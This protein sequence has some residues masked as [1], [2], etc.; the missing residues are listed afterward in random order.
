MAATLVALAMRL[1]R[2]GLRPMHTDEAVHAVKFG[3][4][5]EKGHYRYDPH[6]YHGPTLNYLTLIPAWLSSARKLTDINEF[7]LRIVPVFFGTLLVLLL[8]PVAGGLGRTAAVAAA[9]LTA[10]SPAMVFYSRYYI[11]EMLMVCFTFGAIISGYRYSQ[12]KNIKWALLTGVSLGLLYATKETCIIVFGSMLLALLLTLIMQ[13]RQG[14]SVMITIRALNPWHVILGIVAAAVV[15]ALFYSSFLTNAGGIADSVLAWKAYIN[16]AAQNEWHLHPW[17]YY[18]KMLIYS[19]YDSGP[20]WSEA[21][22]IV[23]AGIGFF[24]AMKNKGLPSSDIHLIRFIAFYALIMT[25]LFSV[26][27]YKTPWNLL[28]FFHGMVLLAGVGVMALLRYQTN[29]LPRVLIS[30]LLVAGGVH[31]TWQACRANYRYYADAANPYVYAHTSSDVVDIS[32]HVGEIADSHPDGHDLNVEVI[33]PGDDYWP[34]PWYLRSFTSIGWWSE[35]DE[36]TP[37]APIVIISPKVEQ[38]LS[39]KL[40][41][42]PAPGKRDLYVPLFSSYKELRPQ[43]ELR[44]YVV[45]ELWDRFQQHRVESIPSQPK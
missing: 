25:V 31:L 42:S 21:L 36:E 41:E 44:G 30:L 26:I 3:S 43:V 6:E 28:G 4:L 29:R 34:L 9:L 40:Y 17:Y 5:L 35:V 7:T 37:A 12:C 33:C 27:P 23:L 11:Q 10:V 14:D 19:R 2:L 1:P 45:K 39:R 15:S 24:A 18:L 13:S 22:V 38:A 32:R 20:V 8:L 16:R